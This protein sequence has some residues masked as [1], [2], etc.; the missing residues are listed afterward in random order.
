MKMI[1]LLIIEDE[2]SLRETW[3][4]MLSYHGFSAHAAANGLDGIKIIENHPIELIITDL[5]MPVKDGYFVLNHLKSN[6]LNIRTWVCTGHISAD[7][8]KYNVDKIIL[9][10]FD[11]LKEIQ[12]II[13]VLNLDSIKA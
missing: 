1:N 11:M 9:K 12:E 4:L 7:L 5:Q 13:S 3:D 2:T 6:N 8:E 10:P